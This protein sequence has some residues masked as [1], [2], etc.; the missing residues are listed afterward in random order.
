[1]SNRSFSISVVVP[2]YNEEK[3][4]Q[5]CLD[6]IF[7]QGYPEDLLEVIVVDNCSTDRTVDKAKQYPVRILYNEIKHPEISKM[8]GFRESNSD[9]FMYLDADIELVRENWFSKIITPLSENKTISGAFPRYTPKPSHPALARFLRYHPLELD[10]VFQFF[11]KKIEDTVV[12]RD[13]RYQICRFEPKDLPPVGICLYRRRHLEKCLGQMS[14]F[15]DIQVPAILSAKGYNLFAYVPSC[16]LYHNS[17]MSIRELLS[18]R[19]R[20]INSIYLPNIENRFFTY[21]DLDRPSEIMKIVSWIVYANV[22]FPETLRAI[23]DSI[24]HRDR[25]CFYRPLVALVMTDYIVYRFVRNKRGRKILR[26]KILR[27]LTKRDD[28]RT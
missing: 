6:S 19:R 3:R 4:I 16:K 18:K 21:F 7:R 5:S 17:S 25:A 1:M 24:K 2:T 26:E 23:V 14:H 27:K 8:I 9:L 13:E 15:M 11:C 20:N 12:W 22:F 10:P 28:E